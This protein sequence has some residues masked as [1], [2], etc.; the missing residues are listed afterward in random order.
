MRPP[1]SI[2]IYGRSIRLLETRRWM[3]EYAGFAAS[4]ASS[5][6]DYAAITLRGRPNVG[7]IR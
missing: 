3:Q 4:G 1:P 6:D 7:L 5:P 2:L